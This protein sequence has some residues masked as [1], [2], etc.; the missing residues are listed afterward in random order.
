MLFLLLLVLVGL[1]WSVGCEWS[2]CAVGGCMLLVVD[3]WGQT[4]FASQVVLGKA[5]WEM[6]WCRRPR[7]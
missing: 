4:A 3:E 1:C 2:R 5:G 7:Q 6:Q